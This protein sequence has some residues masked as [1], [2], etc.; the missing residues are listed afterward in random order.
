MTYACETW[1]LSA[2][3]EKK[4]DA[5]DRKIMRRI[6][7]VRWFKKQTNEELYRITQLQ[8]LSSFITKM[9]L[10]W[11]GHVLRFEDTNVVKQIL[12]WEP[13]GS[14]RPVGR[15][16]FRFCDTIRKDAQYCGT[17]ATMRALE[18]LA[19]DRKQWRQFVAAA[20]DR[21]P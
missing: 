3:Q 13:E 7:K 2:K 4:L 17:S 8:P 12:F 1:A 20:M 16:I 21:V 6:L 11:L 15:P 14:N 10:K 9:R 5:T 18:N 19:Q